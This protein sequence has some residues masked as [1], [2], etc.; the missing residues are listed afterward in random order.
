[1]LGFLK[2]AT[3]LKIIIIVKKDGWLPV[4]HPSFLKKFQIINE[5]T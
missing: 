5:T 2:N 4:R 3:I 1:M